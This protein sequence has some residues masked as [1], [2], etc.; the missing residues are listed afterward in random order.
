MRS[1]SSASRFLVCVMCLACSG[2][3]VLA[4]AP[5][6]AQP[7]P[8]LDVFK[9]VVFDPTTYAPGLVAYEAHHLDW[10]SSQVFFEHGYLEDNPEFTLSGL[11]HDV[12]VSYAAGN[13][14]IAK[15]GFA[16][17][18]VSLLHN[19]AVAVLERA[20]IERFPGHRHLVRV[21]GWTERIAFAS[22]LSYSQSA[23]HFRQWQRNGDLA[24][25]LG[26]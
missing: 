8:L 23:V 4:E 6:T 18:G 21:L 13:R 22:Y 12:P 14:Q 24:R 17:L 2:M 10:S 7:S 3:S 11:A 5:P 16:T 20:A 9:R 15:T 1:R 26:Y 25:Q 19:T